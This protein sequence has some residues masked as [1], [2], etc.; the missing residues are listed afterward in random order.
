MFEDVQFASGGVVLRGRLYRDGESTSL[1]PAVVMTHGFSATLTMGVDRYAEVFGE[2]GFVVLLYDHGGFG[3]SDG[4]PRQIINPWVQARGYLD[5]VSYLR[6]VD[7]V[8]PSRIA[9]WGDSLS[10]GEALIVAAVDERVAAVVAQVP[11][12]GPREAP[13]DRDGAL[14][15]DLRHTVFDGDITGSGGTSVGPLPVVSADQLGTPSLLTPIT[16]FRWFIEYGARHGSGWENVAT[17]MTPDT[18]APFHP[19][20]C[21]PHLRI[22]SL[23]V[24]APAD[25][26]P[27]ANPAVARKAYESAGGDKHVLEI[28]GGHFGLLYWPSELFD[29]AATAQRDFLKRVL[30]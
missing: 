12:C 30:D 18:P 14:F 6:S 11:V 1:R 10:G 4:D 17:L 21:S 20:L 29:V 7:G 13:E 23:W 27:A 22:P 5:A 8:D 24:L 2:A 19:A 16:A 25:E 3:R 28:G 9:V 15:A 26:M